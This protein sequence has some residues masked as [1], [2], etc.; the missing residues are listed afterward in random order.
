MMVGLQFI[1]AMDLC[2]AT[3]DSLYYTPAAKGSSKIGFSNQGGCNNE[4]LYSSK[5]LK[6]IV[7]RIR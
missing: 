7:K 2:V 3:V 5:V 6:V 1:A 4:Y